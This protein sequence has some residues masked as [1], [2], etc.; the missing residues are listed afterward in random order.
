M[1]ED[2]YNSSGDDKPEIRH[3]TIARL[4]LSNRMTRHDVNNEVPSATEENNL[5]EVQTITLDGDSSQDQHYVV[6]YASRSDFDTT[7]SEYEMNRGDF[8]PLEEYNEDRS[9]PENLVTPTGF[10]IA[11]RLYKCR[12]CNFSTM[13]YTQLQLHMPKHGGVKALKCPL[14]DYSTNDKSNFRRHKRLHL[15]NNPVNVLKCDKCTYSTILPR[16]IREHYCEEHVDT[17]NSTATDSATV[18]FTGPTYEATRFRFR[19]FGVDQS[20]SSGNPLG[21]STL[22]TL[23]TTVQS[24][25][26]QFRRSTAAPINNCFTQYNHYESASQQ[27]NQDTHL[28]SNY[29]RSIVSSIMN[30]PPPPPRVP[31]T[32]TIT[33][34]SLYTTAATVATPTLPP[35]STASIGSSTATTLPMVTDTGE[36]KVKV[37]PFECEEISDVSS[38]AAAT[39]MRTLTPDCSRDVQT[40]LSTSSKR[41]SLDYLENS[42]NPFDRS[43]ELRTMSN[44][45]QST[46]DIADSSNARLE[47]HS[48]IEENMGSVENIAST[49]SGKNYMENTLHTSNPVTNRNVMCDIALTQNCSETDVD[50]A[51]VKRETSSVAVQCVLPNVKN[52]GLNVGQEEA[53]ERKRWRCQFIERAV[54]CELLP[55]RRTGS[56]SVSIASESEGSEQPS[57]ATTTDNRCIYCGVTFEDEVLFSIHIGCHSHTDPFVCNVCGKQCTNKYGFYSHIMRGHQY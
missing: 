27:A 54:Q 33:S 35:S 20:T 2:P 9:S 11:A 30:S 14:C 6:N 41:Q 51:S 32:S 7:R 18:P 34:S 57:T 37:E 40:V 38:S 55:S 21:M 26:L 22:H 1:E 16:K 12:F 45:S 23:L 10:S 39:P 4:L 43:V 13:K 24:P 5:N 49:S 36:V 42:S 47:Y 46:G 53:P 50:S 17:P 29:L 31:V 48:P 28:A 44:V 3:S 56:R 15:R 8:S 52:E 19:H 25:N